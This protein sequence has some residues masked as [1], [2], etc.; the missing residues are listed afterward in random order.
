MKKRI[1]PRRLALCGLFA[2]LIAVGAFIRIP[3]FT[4]PITLQTLFVVLAGLLLG[5]SAGA[6]SAL[7]YLLLGLVGLPIFTQGGGVMYVLKPSFGYILGFVAGAWITGRIAWAVSAPRFLR[8]FMAGIAGMLVI[9][10]VGVLYFW[11]ISAVYLGNTVTAK[12]LL[13][14]CFLIFVPGDAASVAVAAVLSLRLLPL[15]RR[16][17]GRPAEN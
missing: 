15:L 1:D 4:V 16:L 14:S 3:T 6:L 12:T 7:V 13:V 17:F 5:P 2:A 10:A 11:L 8:L 9:Y